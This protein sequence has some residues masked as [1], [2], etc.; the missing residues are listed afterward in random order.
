MTSFVAAAAALSVDSMTGANTGLPRTSIRDSLVSRSATYRERILPSIGSADGQA[1]D[2][3]VKQGDLADLLGL[4][5]VHVNRSLMELRRQRLGT[6]CNRRFEI[7]RLRDLLDLAQ[8]E[9]A[10]SAS[11]LVGAEEPVS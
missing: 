3:P 1:F 4:S 10:Y 2:L 9:P 8:F 7:L 5:A 6:W 11:L